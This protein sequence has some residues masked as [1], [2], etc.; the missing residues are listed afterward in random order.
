[1]EDYGKRLADIEARLEALE[2]AFAS[3]VP[4]PSMPNMF[5]TEQGKNNVPFECAIVAQKFR[6]F[7]HPK[8]SCQCCNEFLLRQEIESMVEAMGINTIKTLDT[9]V[10]RKGRD[11]SEHFWQLR[12]R[13]NLQPSSNNT[14][15]AQRYREGK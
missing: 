5:V 10:D 14:G 1:M 12:K 15:Q 7:Q 6:F 3:R 8:R 9:E 13:M 2:E 4:Q 11:R